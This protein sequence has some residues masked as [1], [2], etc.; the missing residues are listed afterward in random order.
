MHNFTQGPA[1]KQTRKEHKLW[2]DSRERKLQNVTYAYLGSLL[3]RRIPPCLGCMPLQRDGLQPPR[4]WQLCIQNPCWQLSLS[5][6]E[7]ADPDAQD[8]YGNTVLHMVVIVEQLGGKTLKESFIWRLTLLLWPGMFGYALKHPIKKANHLV[9][10]HRE[11]TSLT[12]SCLLG[13]FQC[14]TF[15]C[16]IFPFVLARVEYLDMHPRLYFS[17][18][19]HNLS[20]L[21]ILSLH[22]RPKLASLFIVGGTNH[23][24]HA[25][26]AFTTI[27]AANR[28]QI[29]IL[30]LSGT[31]CSRRCWRWAVLSFGGNS[32]I[33]KELKNIY[34]YT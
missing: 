15:L 27:G 9:R 20:K 3:P 32:L 23:F 6:E 16:S 4:W 29:Q 13:R 5:T 7:G 18:C 24:Y 11:L 2:G 25:T 30:K 33:H 12:L 10:N 14:F 26:F 21:H 28:K 34:R 8:T 31:Q 17:M 19:S 1:D 22:P